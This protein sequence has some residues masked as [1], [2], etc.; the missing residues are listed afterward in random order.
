MY[1]KMGAQ[2]LSSGATGP[3]RLDE[4]GYLCT[5]GAAG[6]YAEAA[7]AGRL[8]HSANIN[9]VTTS[10]T[11]NTTFV[12]LGLCNPA[13][14]GK[15]VI[16]H[17]FGYAFVAASA[18]GLIL[19]LAVTDDTGFAQDANAPIICAKYAAASSVCLTDEGATITAPT[20]IKVITQRADAATSAFQSYPC[21]VD[22]GGS[23]VLPPGYAVVT[24]TTTAA[25]A[26]TAQFSFM[27]EEVDA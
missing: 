14:S 4:F 19:A 22:L 11:L 2:S 6:K 23:I 16:V 5:R 3:L 7:L 24:D 17:E 13:G 21:V 9:M 8:F 10:T 18:A 20:I 15:N 26:S 25:G 27:W 1:G 12:G